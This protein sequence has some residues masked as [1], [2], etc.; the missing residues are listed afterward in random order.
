MQVLDKTVHV[1]CSRI[2]ETAHYCASSKNSVF[3]KVSCLKVSGIWSYEDL[4]TKTQSQVLQ[5]RA[6]DMPYNAMGIHN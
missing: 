3:L 4:I 5:S 6:Y 1:S 2:S